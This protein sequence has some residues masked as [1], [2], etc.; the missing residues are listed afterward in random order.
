[1]ASGARMVAAAAAP[2]AHC[3]PLTLAPGMRHAPSP[4]TSVDEGATHC[5]TGIVA[6]ASV[7]AASAARYTTASSRPRRDIQRG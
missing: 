3:G 4:R 2:P 5:N 7:A 6:A 1:M